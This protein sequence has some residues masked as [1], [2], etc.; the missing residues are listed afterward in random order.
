M[1]VAK[2]FRA[3][4]DQRQTDVTL[5]TRLT[6]SPM[7]AFGEGGP[8]NPLS[9]VTILRQPHYVTKRNRT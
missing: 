8:E 5:R 4:S 2:K 6:A 9:A 7:M 1:A 3:R